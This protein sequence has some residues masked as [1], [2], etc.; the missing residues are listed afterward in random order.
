MGVL[1]LRAVGPLGETVLDPVQAELL[2]VARWRQLP[3]RFLPSRYPSFSALGPLPA[4]VSGL[5]AN[6]VNGPIVPRD[7]LLGEIAAL[8]SK[9][10]GK[11]LTLADEAFCSLLQ[12][13]IGKGL[14]T[15]LFNDP[16]VWEDYTKPTLRCSAPFGWGL[17][18]A[19]SEKWSHTEAKDQHNASVLG[20]ESALEALSE[21]LGHADCFGADT[22]APGAEGDALNRLDA[23][24]YAHLA[25]LF[26]IPCQKDSWLHKLF[27]RFPTLVQFCDRLETRFDG[28]VWPDHYS[29]LAGVEPSLRLPAAKA[30]AAEKRHRQSTAG[31]L[32]TGSRNGLRRGSSGVN[33]EREDAEGA[34]ARQGGVGPE[35]LHPSAGT[36]PLEWW[37]F[38]GWSW[39]PGKR[40]Q[41][42]DLK[43]R[44]VDPPP[45]HWPAFLA[46]SSLTLLSAM[47]QGWG[48]PQLYKLL[49]EAV[50]SGK[51]KLGATA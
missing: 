40:L 9:G 18:V 33:T 11:A 13:R 6:G 29:F 1:Q 37:E 3:L 38:W 43:M 12:Q 49:R 36:R 32:R 24:A 30:A 5:R 41:P 34:E 7:Q 10:Y 31:L 21:R 22:S 44:K 35:V 45:W 50:A 8:D 47:L 48:P 14:P 23:C 16:G 27:L 15:L 4:A 25:V 17:T 20:I 26:S 46:M 39:S 51:Q 19:W 2:F 42:A 28:G